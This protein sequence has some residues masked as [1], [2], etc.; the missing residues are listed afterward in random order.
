MEAAGRGLPPPPDPWPAELG[1]DE[2]D[3]INAWIHEQTRDLAL[4]DVLAESEATFDALIAGIQALPKDEAARQRA[5][6]LE[7]TA[8][9]GHP[10][11]HFGE[12]EPSVRDWLATD[13]S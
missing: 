12:H 8:E 1:E 9:D 6:W 10:W 3:P 2:D 5:Q 13:P 7:A 4:A 11:G